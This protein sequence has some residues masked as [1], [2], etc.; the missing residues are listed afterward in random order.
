[1]ICLGT[2]VDRVGLTTTIA[3]TV[4]VLDPNAPSAA[5][6]RT[7]PILTAHASRGKKGKAAKVVTLWLRSSE[8]AAANVELIGTLR[9]HGAHGTLI[10]QSKH[11]SSVSTTTKYSA[12]RLTVK[13]ALA[14]LLAR[15]LSVRV[16][17][18]DLAGNRTEKTVAVR[19]AKGKPAKEKHRAKRK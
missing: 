11:L 7:P 19:P 1:M 9:R 6:D 4:R 13:P 15:K 12:V 8:P 10:M 18:T 2:A 17:L 14:K 3:R 16:T 5:A